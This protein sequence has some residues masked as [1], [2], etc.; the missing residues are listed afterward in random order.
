MFAFCTIIGQSSG[1][2]IQ[3]M[4]TSNSSLLRL[5]VTSNKSYVAIATYDLVFPIERCCPILE[6]Y[7]ETFLNDKFQR[8][9]W[10]CIDTSKDYMDILSGMTTTVAVLQPPNIGYNRAAICIITNTTHYQC[11]GTLKS[12]SVYPDNF[13]LLG[14]YLCSDRNHFYISYTVQFQYEPPPTCEPLHV[15]AKACQRFETDV[16][17]TNPFGAINQ[18]ISYFA[19]GSAAKVVNSKCHKYIQEALCYALFPKCIEGQ[20]Y[21]LFPCR[22]MCTELEAACWNE[23]VEYFSYVMDMDKFCPTKKQQPGCYHPTVYCPQ[24][25]APKHGWLEYNISGRP[26]INTTVTLH[27]QTLYKPN[28]TKARRCQASGEWSG[29]PQFCREI[30]SL[31][32]VLSATSILIGLL[33]LMVIIKSN[34]Y[35]IKVFLYAKLNISLGRRL[36]ANDK[37]YDAYVMHGYEQFAFVTEKLA[38]KLE[39]KFKLAIPDRDLIPGHSK[40]S[41]LERVIMESRTVI[42]VLSQDFLNKNWSRWE[43]TQALHHEIEQSNFKVIRYF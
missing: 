43:L 8:I 13:L 5:A 23:L 6:F 37:I 14:N 21:P 20:D 18:I 40:M 3:G 28:D 10:T 1:E 41:E 26:I 24:L 27:C 2:I 34:S 25:T 32:L 11:N 7:G 12:Y 17:P 19:M 31:A 42:V 33:V 22:E 36:A 4:D 39:P 9:N 30:V 15:G 38:Q 35:I 16:L 29:D